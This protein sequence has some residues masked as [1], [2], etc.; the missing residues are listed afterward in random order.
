MS[1]TNNEKNNFFLPAW[2]Y[3][4]CIGLGRWSAELNSASSDVISS[5]GTCSGAEKFSLDW[6]VPCDIP[7]HLP[8]MKKIIFLRS[9]KYVRCIGLHRWSAE[10]NSASNDLIISDGTCSGTE[11]FSLDWLLPCDIPCHLPT[12]KKIIFSAV[13]KY[14]R[15]IGLGRWS[16]ELNSA[17]NDVISSDGTC[18]G[19]R[20]FS[21]EWVLPCD[22]ECQLPLLNKIIVF[23]RLEICPVHRTWSIKCRIEFCI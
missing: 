19:A 7:C 20:K 4:R 15:C 23:T 6:L 14:V 11:K 2:K 10:L 9:R 12:T 21:L 13:W 16:A 17:S 1:P 8:T 3:V 18:S 5:H 22:K